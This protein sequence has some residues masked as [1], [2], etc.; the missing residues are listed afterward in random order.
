MLVEENEALIG[1][2][3]WAYCTLTSI[4][5]ILLAKKRG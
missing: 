1:G 3:I 2:E 5:D 4:S